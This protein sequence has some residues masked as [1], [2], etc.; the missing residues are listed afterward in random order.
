MAL[1]TSLRFAVDA[2]R[3]N[4]FRSVL[5]LSGVVLGVATLI[6]LSA[7]LDAL[8]R[9]VRET[10]EEHGA[11]T[12]RVRRERRWADATY[13]E[14]VSTRKPIT[15]SE[16]R[17]LDERRS[18]TDM[19]AGEMWDWG[20]RVSSGGRTTGPTA[21]VVGGAPGFL[22]AN[23]LRLEH[24]R[25]LTPLDLTH[26]TQVAVIGADLVQALFPKG[27]ASALGEEIL[28]GRA[29]FRVVGTIEPLPT[30][31]GMGGGS[32][33]SL[34]LIPLSTFE[35]QFGSR[36]LFITARAR[37]PERLAEAIDEARAILRW[38]RRVPADA[39]DDFLVTDNREV[40]E[41]LEGI[42]L[43]LMATAGFVSLISLVVGGVSIA[44]LM[45]VTVQLRTREIGL[46]L[47]IGARPSAV[48]WQFLLEAALLS[49]CGGLA[50][51]AIG[52]GGVKLAGAVLQLDLAVSG[53]SIVA[54]VGVSVVVGLLAGGYPAR[55]A[56]NLDPVQALRTD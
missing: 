11:G 28:V 15:S 19:V 54:G 51:I 42:S 1:L 47:A 30:P 6:A 17:A 2:L 49:G 24:G 3:A 56:S 46:R 4:P 21:A 7:A 48:L 16:L 13:K 36:S 45:L 33:N 23:H 44:N 53:W 41:L 26:R 52:W 22:E 10:L 35:S 43:L 20:N 50:G 27:P 31:L 34:V 55:R 29:Y 9:T 38:V 39:P 12:F 14:E 5:T 18:L 37:S 40:A 8:G 32:R 25:S